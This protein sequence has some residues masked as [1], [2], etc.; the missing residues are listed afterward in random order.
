MLKK[1]KSFISVRLVAVEY[2]FLFNVEE[3]E[4][5]QEKIVCVI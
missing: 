5:K 4:K 2:S 1:F 3:P